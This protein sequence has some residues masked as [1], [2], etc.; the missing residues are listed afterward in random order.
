[1]SDFEGL[2]KFEGVSIDNQGFV[3]V[4]RVDDVVGYITQRR[5]KEWVFSSHRSYIFRA[6]EL[7]CIAV[8]LNQLNGV[9]FDASMLA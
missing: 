2:T 4:S 5:S 9:A 1:M 8:W 6:N 3:S 7:I